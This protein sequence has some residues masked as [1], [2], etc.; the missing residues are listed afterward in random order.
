MLARSQRHNI[1]DKLFGNGPGVAATA[2]G[3]VVFLVVLVLRI[4]HSYVAHTFD[5]QENHRM[6]TYVQY[7]IGSFQIAVLLLYYGA[8]HNIAKNGG[9]APLHQECMCEYYIQGAVGMTQ[10]LMRVMF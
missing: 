8:D 5:L 10:C 6:L 4:N 3:N 1:G 2:P 7:N 9:E